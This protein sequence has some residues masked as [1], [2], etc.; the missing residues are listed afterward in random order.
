M[1]ENY[2][3][4]GIG[5]F[6]YVR[7][8]EG[9]VEC[10]AR[11]IF[12]KKGITPV[13]G[14]WVRLAEEKGSFEMCIRDRIR[15]PQASNTSTSR[16]VCRPRPSFWLIW[17]VRWLKSGATAF[18]RVDLPTPELPQKAQKCPWMRWRTC[19]TPAPVW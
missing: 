12:R 11:G 5:G 8:P 14:D 17:P 19:S 2:I 10:K 1:K 16:V 18:S 13:A 6:Y 7:T 4:K 9:V 15:P 3:V